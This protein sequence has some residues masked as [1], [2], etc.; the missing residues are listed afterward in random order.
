MRILALVAL[1][2]LFAAG[3]VE[4]QKV[5]A[6][7]GTAPPPPPA[8]RPLTVVSTPA[9]VLPTLIDVSLYQFMTS[10][11]AISQN[12]KFWDLTEPAVTSDLLEENGLRVALGSVSDWPRFKR[13]FDRVG[14]N[15]VHEHYIA[16]SATDQEIAVSG[17]LPEQTLFV[18]DGHG[19][20]GRV[21]D[22]CQN[23][24]ALSYG[25]SP[26]A[27]GNMRLELCPLVRGLRRYYR[28]TV[29]N[30]Q[31]A[32]NYTSD[33]QF[34][35]LG[36]RLDVPEGKFLIVCPSE[37]SQ[38][39]TSVGHQFLTLDAKAGRRE[40]ILLF[41]VNSSPKVLGSRPEMKE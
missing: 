7:V 10:A 3:C 24:M 35:D 21:Y 1:A 9:P 36:L 18:F 38:R 29:I 26:A 40:R 2:T 33:E 32:L 34:Y 13:I 30:D 8:T 17:E 23:L 41:V 27:E 28:Y 22:R 14:V 12:Q 37:Q 39:S 19:L 4:N 20:S 5:A 31:Q 15:V 25:P 16:A 11:G 6:E